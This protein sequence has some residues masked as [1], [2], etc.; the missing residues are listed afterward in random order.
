MLLLRRRRRRQQHAKNS[1]IVS[2]YDVC[3]RELRPAGC[4][5]LLLI[6][7]DSPLRHPSSILLL[8][9]PEEERL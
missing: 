1:S 8:I 9:L 5:R 7:I 2:H 3:S 4:W 6:F